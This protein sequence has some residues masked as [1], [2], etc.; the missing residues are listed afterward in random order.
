MLRVVTLAN[1][2]CNDLFFF[3]DYSLPKERVDGIWPNLSLAVFVLY[4]CVI[5]IADRGAMIVCADQFGL[6]QLGSVLQQLL[7]TALSHRLYRLLV[8][9]YC[10]SVIFFPRLQARFLTR[11]CLRNII[12]WIG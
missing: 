10:S 4:S 7:T 1:S 12:I 2:D 8:F 9:L 11:F 5:C 6:E 3:P